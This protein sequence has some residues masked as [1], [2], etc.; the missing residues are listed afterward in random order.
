V[1][2]VLFV[3]YVLT[4]RKRKRK[5]KT[6][7]YYKFDKSVQKNMEVAI[8]LVALGSLYFLSSNKN[9]NK[10]ASLE[11]FNGGN[12]SASSPS[13]FSIG[14]A[15]PNIDVPNKNYPSEYPIENPLR[16]QTS[17]LSKNN[18]YDGATFT[19][20]FF[21]PAVDPSLL[22]K[23]GIPPGSNLD[24]EEN[25]YQSMTG[26]A[27]D[28]AYFQ[29]NN[30]VP[31][32][33]SKKRTRH[34]A[35]DRNES[36]LDNYNGTGSQI[37]RKTEQAPLFSPQS[38][39]QFAYGMP[40]QSD[41]IQS[42]MNVSVKMSNVK[43]FDD[44][45]VGPGLGLGYGTEGQG[46]YNSGMM[47]RDQWREK[48]VDE[49]RVANKPKAGG[50]NALGY[51]G[52]ANLFVKSAGS[53]D[54]VGRFEKNRPDSYFDVTP[55][56]YFTTIGVEHGHSL[57]PLPIAK[58]QSRPEIS[59]EYAGGAG[60]INMQKEY[61]NGEYREPRT[62]QLGPVPLAVAD[63]TRRGAATTND[64][65]VM[66]VKAYGNNR[67]T[68]NNQKPTYYGGAGNN[69]VIAEAF[70]PLLDLIRPSRKENTIGTLR[71]YQNAKTAVPSPYIYNPQDRP[72][73][74]IKET[75]VNSMFHLNTN[76]EA[77]GAYDST[78]QQVVPQ[79]RDS[80]SVYYAGGSDAPAY[81]ANP[82]SREAELNQTSNGIKSASLRGY[83]PSGNIDT[84]NATINARTNVSTEEMMMNHREMV[85]VLPI[86]PEYFQGRVSSERVNSAVYD[87]QISLDRNN[88]DVLKQL[89]ENPYV[90]P[91]NGKSSL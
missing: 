82:R 29:H 18:Q 85:P 51:E 42:R 91:I 89:K 66:G 24:S 27:V 16:D 48:T 68:N 23:N 43:P 41:F 78:P 35:N 11:N 65:S 84:F 52:P 57:I 80:T 34:D 60:V 54:R 37:I 75:T 81:A 3:F 63:R 30:M 64:Y 33:G 19:D 28:A 56:R 50:L 1:F 17:S 12:L 9:K 70:A 69:G 71:P 58:D 62:Q 31:F 59:A 55:D 4:K 7:I 61:V 22:G 39:L 13:P 20:K 10:N 79:Q 2:Y 45:K 21:N 14:G 5:N 72:L 90:L 74:T 87:S 32:F 49:L 73:P 40:N 46:G 76:L 53:N 47:A 15:L 26:Q 88:G 67:S 36:I 25:K 6:C 86:N 38:N 8:P 44:E 83:A 77:K